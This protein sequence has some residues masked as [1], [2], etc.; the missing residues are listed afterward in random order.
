MK[1]H[2]IKINKSKILL[3]GATF[4]ENT[5]DIELK[6]TDNS[7]PT[8]QKKAELIIYDPFLKIKSIKN[9]KISKIYPKNKKFDV[10]IL[11]VKHKEFKS[12]T[13]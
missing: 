7:K 13:L 9:L 3:L 12:L 11:A 6:S 1:E 10:I 5:T 8:S 2:N 4:K